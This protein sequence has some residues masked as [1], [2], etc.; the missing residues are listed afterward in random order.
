MSFFDSPIG[1]C[2]AV[3]EMVLLDETQQEC[4]REHDCPAGRLCPLEGYFAET[5]ETDVRSVRPPAE[6]ATAPRAGRPA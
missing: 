2:D 6:S 5:A 4:A 1:R 3:H